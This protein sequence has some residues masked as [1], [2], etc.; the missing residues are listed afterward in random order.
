[1]PD[2]AEVVIAGGGPVG[3]L[4]AAEL[5]LGGVDVVVLEELAQPTGQSRAG[6]LHPRSIELLDQRGLLD[7]FPAALPK[8]PQSHFAALGPL[9][10]GEMASRHPY[11]LGVPQA[12][13]ERV[14]ED[15]FL[16]A[17]GQLR[18]GHRVVGLEQDA[19]GVSAQVSGPGGSYQVRA[20]Y[21]VGCDGGG[22]TVRKLAGIDFPG[23]ESTMGALMGE[24]EVASPP[25][26]G[27]GAGL[28]GSVRGAGDYLYGV[29]KL[30]WLPEGVY[31]V[32]VADFSRPFPDRKAPVDIEEMRAALRA[33]A[34]DDYGIHSP[35]WLSRF[36]DASRQAA[37]YRS[38]RVLLAG[39]AA[40]IHWPGGGQGLNLGLHDAVN[41]G[42]KLAGV[43]RGWAGDSL[44]DSYHA[45]CHPLGERVLANTRAQQVLMDP[46]PRY[47]ELRALFA[48]VMRTREVNSQL[49]EM[50]SGL[51]VV[52]DFAGAAHPLLGRRMPD[53]D[54]KT[55]DGR[56]RVAELLRAGRGVLLDF[57][58]GLGSVA[59]PWA[60]RVDVVAGVVDGEPL[61]VDAVLLRPDG[62]VAWVLPAG[63]TEADGL[64]AALRT[65]FG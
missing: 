62:H 29:R 52:Y 17:G 6:G 23:T 51:D 19:D 38:G 18:R 47:A 48:D 63:E 53:V 55:S 16:A 59:E 22:S 57:G 4:L 42:W 28:P 3:L 65:W 44:L 7:R 12:L 13:T 40:H 25:A 24:M 41:L 58:A 37:S 49:A 31:R 45:E 33:A 9:A 1:M 30:P 61:A 21:L 26:T 5:R 36:G 56:S 34:G 50:I 14:L 10:Y 60:S 11:F 15:H 20:R 46:R 43:V 8:V 35:R 27:V 39:D 2:T 54:V 32:T 64:V